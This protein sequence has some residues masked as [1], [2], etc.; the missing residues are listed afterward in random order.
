MTD[1][2][3]QEWCEQELEFTLGRGRLETPAM[4]AGT[5][6]HAE[7]EAEVLERVEIEVTT[8][9]DK[10]ALRALNVHAGLTQLRQTGMTRELPVFGWL[11]DQ[12]DDDGSTGY[13]MGKQS[14][15]ADADDDGM[16]TGTREIT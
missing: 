15:A 10:W 14:A 5:A 4:A 7:L 11:L 16:T 2:A 3:A 12:N 6:R 9:E 13:T 8:Q 1:L